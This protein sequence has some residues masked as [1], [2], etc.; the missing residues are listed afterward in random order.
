MY[1]LAKKF[2]GRAGGVFSAVFYIWAPYHA[3]DVFV[4]GAMNEAWGL[5]WFPAIL[6][7]SYKLITT[8]VTSFKKKEIMS[9]L[10]NLILLALS[11]TALLTSHNLMVIV[12]TPFFA[13]W[14]LVWLIKSR[15]WKSVT[16]LVFAGLWAFGLAAFFTLPVFLEKNIV[17]TDTLIKGYYEYTAHF[18]SARQLL[19]S[20]FWGY[21][22]SVW[23]E[24]DGMPFQIGWLHW[25]VPLF[26]M[27][28][29][30]IRT[31]KTRKFDQL[32]WVLVLA[33][34]IGAA[35]DSPSFNSNLGTYSSFAVY[36]VSLE[37]LNNGYFRIFLCCGRLG[38]TSSTSIFV[39]IGRFIDAWSNYLQLG[40]LCTRTREAGALNRPRE[41][42]GC[43]LGVAANRRYL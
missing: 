20:R 18:P 27:G 30:A 21:G 2:F 11:W 12:F 22:P 24:N 37:I 42:Y 23:L 10:P 39:P 29:L 40:L 35:A 9:F 28:I 15:N 7:F 1:Y 31:L 41:V 36:S 8:P 3:V 19:F 26:V 6:L 16:P 5:M 38:E 25:I 32:F 14:C 17:Q 33:F 4:R 43:R 34:G 13:I